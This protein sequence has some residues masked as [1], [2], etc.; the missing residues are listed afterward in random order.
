MIYRVLVLSLVV[1]ASA[2]CSV[3]FIYNNLDR[4]ARMGVSDYLDMNPEQRAYFAEEFAKVH[5]W[6]RQTQ[7]PVYAQLLES[8]PG[9]IADGAEMAELE[10]LEAE[11][12][13]WAEDAI[14]QGLP[15]TAH[16]L[17]SLTDEQLADLPAR[18]ERSN[19]EIAEP[20]LNRELDEM[21]AL[22]A[23]EVE[24]AFKRF[25]GRLTAEQQAYLAALSVSYI[26]ERELWAEY[27]R[28][29]QADF[30]KL[31]HQ[32]RE[33]ADFDARFFALA[34]S[35]ESYYGTEL[36]AIFAH[37][38]GLYRQI[39]VWFFNHLTDD[40]RRRLSERLEDIATD[41][42]ELAAQPVDDDLACADCGASR[43]G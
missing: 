21:Q 42:R 8:I 41:F 33:L 10:G 16:I 7:L 5:R 39:A 32:R 3:K 17:R 37:N 18:L 35:R 34:R 4:V 15:M 38:E 40:Q 20:E 24:D 31:L 13:G 29:W 36:T 26:P 30:L 12:R 9:L 1:A 6:H 22:W 27:R 28:R 19:K 43:G 11:M 25:A 2:G 14:E 23:E